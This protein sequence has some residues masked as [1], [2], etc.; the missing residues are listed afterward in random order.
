MDK[1]VRFHRRVPVMQT[2]RFFEWLGSNLPRMQRIM[3]PLLLFCV[4]GVTLFVYWTGG[5]KF[6]FSH[7]MYIPVLLAGFLL[8]M[9]GGAVFGLLGGLALGPLMPIDVSTGEMQSTLNWLYRGGFFVL[10]GFLSGAASD[11]VQSYLRHLHWAARH[12]P[13]TGLPNRIALFETFPASPAD[14]ERSKVS[15]LAVFSIENRTELKS[16]FGLAVLEMAVGQLAQRLQEIVMDEARIHRVDTELLAVL[17]T[18]TDSGDIIERVEELRA[19]AQ[20]PLMLESIPIHVDV[21]L[22]YVTFDALLQKPETY[23]Q[24]AEAAL[25]E[26]RDKVRDCASY[27]A[28]ISAVTRENL[29]LLGELKDAIRDGQLSLEYQ[30]KMVLNTGKV[31]GVE[32]LIRWNHPQRGVIPPEIFIPRAEQSTLINLITRF[33][34]DEALRQMARWRR[35]G[36]E[37][38]MAVNISTR[39]LLQPGFV[40]QVLRLLDQHGLERHLLE[41]EVT[42]TA[43]M[44][45]MERAIAG[46]IRLSE[47]KVIVSIDDFGTG[48]SSLQYL[49]RLPVSLIKI[50]QSFVRKLPGDT[51]A[52]HIV[53]AAITLARKQ[54]IQT[55]AEGVENREACRFL[56][57]MGCDQAQ[58]YFLCRPL[59]ADTFAAWYKENGGHIHV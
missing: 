48:Y 27:S 39:N 55:L 6:V 38:S 53:E 46:L 5:I 57:G 29:R 36:I 50:D 2:A 1:G 56:R 59:A 8:G 34:L 58:G 24:E 43:L 28:S 49:H 15:A 51:G 40:D 45:E 22:G 3:V 47:T 7:S 4:G 10:I 19:C 54:G 26:A 32:A 30:P 37:V 42:E 20:A 12:D 41:L 21:R 52:M 14:R 16:A 9:R 17:L 18:G 44:V 33:A 23:L 13:A 25:I 31:D 35:Q 11:S